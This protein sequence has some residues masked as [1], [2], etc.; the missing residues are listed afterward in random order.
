MFQNSDSWF[1]IDRLFNNAAAS[2]LPSRISLQSCSLGR[3]PSSSPAGSMVMDMESA[4]VVADDPFV[5]PMNCSHLVAGSGSANHSGDQISVG[6]L[7]D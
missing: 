2:C 5:P 6:S 7:S 1:P 4:R 3:R